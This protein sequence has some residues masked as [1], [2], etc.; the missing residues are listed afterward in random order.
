MDL[1]SGLYTTSLRIVNRLA[2]LACRTHAIRKK[3]W[4]TVGLSFMC[5]SMFDTV[6]GFKASLILLRHENVNKLQRNI[7]ESKEDYN[8]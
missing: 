2:R 8:F 5:Y 7:F 3:L 4:L 6:Y 1:L